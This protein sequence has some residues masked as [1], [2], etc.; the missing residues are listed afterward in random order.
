M[1]A[2]RSALLEEIEAG[3][4]PWQAGESIAVPMGRPATIDDLHRT[5][6]RTEI[7]GGQLIVI[8]PCG[9]SAGIAARSILVRLTQ[10]EFRHGGGAAFTSR[11]AFIV[12][13]PH[14]LSFCP[15]VSWYTGDPE[16]T[17]FPLGA[18]VFAAEVRDPAEYGDEAEWRMA[19]KR[20]DYFAAGTRVVWDVDVLREG[21]IR[22]YR[23]GEPDHPAVFH[24][25]QV[26]DGEPAVPGWRFAVDDLFRI[27]KQRNA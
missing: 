1:P 20:A 22:V 17:G 16:A 5:K 11:A 9:G 12:D 15:D 8:G 19:A 14:R 18:P 7:V 6:L 23:A 4:W 21:W 25:G 3:Y 26:V 27:G 2:D 24:R 13:L 10:H